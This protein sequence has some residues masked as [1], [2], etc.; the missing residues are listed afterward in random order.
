MEYKVLVIAADGQLGRLV[1][2]RCEGYKQIDFHFTT[3]DELDVTNVDVLEKIV[4]GQSWDFVINCSAYTA[5]DAAED[6]QEICYAI[7]KQA[8]A[9]LGRFS[10]EIGAKVIHV[11]TDYVFDGTSN[12]PYA[13]EQEI[14]PVSVYGK[15]K[16]DGEV[17]LLEN[18][19]QTVIIRTSWLYSE[20]PNNFYQTM[21][22]LGKVRGE[23]N[24]VFDQIGTPTYGGD[25]ADA[26]LDIVDRVLIMK[27]DF[28]PGVYH[29]SNE[30][31]TSWYD[32]AIAIFELTGINCLVSPVKSDMFP[33]KASRPA[34]SVM[35]KTK[36]KQTYQ[37]RI[38][39]WRSSLAKMIDANYKR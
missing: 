16:A 21:V 4:K 8:V 25:L 29:Y 22:G 32:F 6:N 5:V 19:P 28:V 12:V 15:S 35:D 2:E 18:N 10:A 7:N 34:Y 33:T 39:H 30:G 36:I 37:I 14:N 1:R 3:I 11:S 17:L 20:L 31:V 38:P 26:I 23:L 13:E 27:Q 9:N 24:V